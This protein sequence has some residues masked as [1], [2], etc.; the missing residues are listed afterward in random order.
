MVRS[1]TSFERA[2]RCACCTSVE[3]EPSSDGDSCHTTK[4]GPILV[5]E[6]KI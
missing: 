5:A 4:D 6:I 2:L 3:N 1:H